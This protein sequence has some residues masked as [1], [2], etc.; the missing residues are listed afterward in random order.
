[1]TR[2]TCNNPVGCHRNDA[3]HGFIVNTP[4]ATVIPERAKLYDA[5]AALGLPHYQSPEAAEQTQLFHQLTAPFND[6][7]KGL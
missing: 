6:Y 3:A 2:C 4:I 7:R 1:M 5:H